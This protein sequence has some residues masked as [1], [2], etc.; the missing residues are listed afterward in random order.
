MTWP[1]RVDANKR[2][3]IWVL[4][5]LLRNRVSGDGRKCH[6][7]GNSTMVDLVLVAVVVLVVLWNCWSKD[8]IRSAA[9]FNYSTCHDET[10]PKNLPS[11]RFAYMYTV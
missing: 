6:V 3:C 10:F 5:D 4:F 1:V 7:W 8:M 9:S 2:V 11:F